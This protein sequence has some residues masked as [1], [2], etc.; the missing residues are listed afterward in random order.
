MSRLSA[1][2]LLSFIF[3]AP[4]LVLASDFD[5]S[6]PFLCAVTE[7]IECDEDNGCSE[8]TVENM[9]IPQFIRVDSKKKMIS[10]EVVS[11]KREKKKTAIKH[12]ERINGKMILQGAEGG[13]GWSMVVGE[14][15]GKM[16]AS[17]SEDQVGFLLF[18]ACTM[19]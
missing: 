11:S 17:I 16:S 13:R 15:S 2:L 19:L 5:G 9:D 14:S 18:G 6:K 3:F 8:V 7:A 1:L 10:A 4:Q 12:L